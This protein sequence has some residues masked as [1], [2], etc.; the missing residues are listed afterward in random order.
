[1]KI[2]VWSSSLA[3]YYKLTLGGAGGQLFLDHGVNL[4]C[5]CCVLSEVVR[6]KTNLSAL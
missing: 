6:V 2:R 4:F 5:C 3:C 1:M